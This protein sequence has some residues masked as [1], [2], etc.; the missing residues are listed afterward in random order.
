VE[1]PSCEA[2]QEYVDSGRYLWNSGMFCFKAG[3]VLEQFKIYAPAIYEHALPCWEAT[4]NKT[5]G[6]MPMMEIDPESFAAIPEN[7]IDYAVM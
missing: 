7:S 6:N 4:R 5:Q 1:K 3:T 2:V